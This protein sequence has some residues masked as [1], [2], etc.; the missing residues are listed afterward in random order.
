MI[1]IIFVSWREPSFLNA[2]NLLNILNQNSALAIV[3]M[4]MTLVIILGG[5]DLSVGSLMAFA[6]GVGIL[7]LNAL[8][9]ATGNTTLAVTVALVT[10]AAVGAA[11][12]TINGILITKGRIE[13]FIATLGTLVAYRSAAQWMAN[14]GQFTSDDKALLPLLGR[15]MPIPFTNTARPGAQPW[16]LYLPT[17]VLVLLGVALAAYVLL[18]RT[19]LGRYM[20]AIGCN[21]RAAVYSAISVAR[22]KVA[23]YTF[24]GLATGIAAVTY[25]G[26]FNSVSSG[27]TGLLLELKVIAAVVIGG[28]RMQGGS[29]SV[30][31]A[32]IGVMLIGVIDNAMIMLGLRSH[33]Q[34]LVMGLII[35][36]A[37]LL[38][39]LAPRR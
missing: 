36:A 13:P 27:S 11:A 14:G 32:L 37:V 8:L 23:A 9:A 16:P 33:A 28:T 17:S 38:Q 4:G 22:V 30:V 25:L 19:R 10:T 20:V 26:R 34:G 31:G 15:G 5:I 35:I 24:I 29:G 3:A 12:G 21:E 2:G 7:T 18:N 39:R 6:G 1:L